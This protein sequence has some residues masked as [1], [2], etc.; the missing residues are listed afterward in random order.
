MKKYNKIVRDR[1]PEVIR[2]NNKTCEVSFVDDKTAIEYLVKKISEE[3]KEFEESGYDKKELADLYEVVDAVR[4][5]LKIKNSQISQI[6]RKKAK[7][8]GIFNNNIV[9][10]SVEE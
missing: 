9:L 1:I 3:A 10:K 6:R 2:Q 7:E 4:D 5:K 8:R